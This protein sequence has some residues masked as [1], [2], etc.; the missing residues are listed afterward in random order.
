ME[1]TLDA[2]KMGELVN[3]KPKLVLEDCKS[4]ISHYEDLMLD[5]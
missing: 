1:I 5:I 2:A 4:E 3:L